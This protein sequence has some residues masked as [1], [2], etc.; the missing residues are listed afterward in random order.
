M[1]SVHEPDEV[2][3]ETPIP[4]K[5]ALHTMRLLMC[6]PA[7]AEELAH[8]RSIPCF[9]QGSS[10]ARKAILGRGNATKPDV[11]RWA[12]LKGHSPQ[13]DNA[14]DALLLLAYADGGAV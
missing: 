2:W 8:R 7:F 3:Y 5:N 12:V 11:V 14:A 4:S 13:D 10:T 1:I 6:L 9:E